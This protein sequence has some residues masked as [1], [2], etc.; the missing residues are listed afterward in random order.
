MTIEEEAERFAMYLK[1]LGY[2]KPVLCRDCK[3]HK[4]IYCAVYPDR[5]CTEHEEYCCWGRR[6]EK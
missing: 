5:D 6:K 3:F 2:V 4:T 1:Q